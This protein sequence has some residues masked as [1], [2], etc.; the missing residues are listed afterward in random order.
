MDD[1]KQP[2]FRGRF[3]QEIFRILFLGFYF[4]LGKEKRFTA[5][6]DVSKYQARL[7]GMLTDISEIKTNR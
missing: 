7:L 5:D 3:L 1:E 6:A 4:D 2:A